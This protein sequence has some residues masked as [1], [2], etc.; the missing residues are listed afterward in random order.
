MR[1]LFFPLICL[2]LSA[3]ALV[4][5]QEQSR[6]VSGQV[7]A[8]DIQSPIADCHVSLYAESKRIAICTT[9]DQGNFSTRRILLDAEKRYTLKITHVNYREESVTLQNEK[10]V[11]VF[12]TPRQQKLDEVVVY[13]SFRNTNKGN[14]YLYTPSEAA[15]S[16]SIVGEPDVVRHIAAMPGVSQGME[17]TLGLYVRGSNN[18]N[19]QILLDGMPVQGSS[20][21]GMFSAF[22]PDMIHETVF[23]MGGTSA[24]SGNYTS[25]LIEIVPKKQYGTPFR[26]KVTLSPYLAGGYLSVPLLKDRISL[27]VG[28][29]LSYLPYIMDYIVNIEQDEDEREDMNGQLM[30]MTA[31][32]DWRLNERNILSA[33]FYTTHDFF[34]YRTGDDQNRL[35]WNSTAFNLHWGSQLAPNMKLDVLAYYTSSYARQEQKTYASYASDQVQSL[36]RLGTEQTEWSGKATWMHQLSD[37]LSYTAGVQVQ[38]L[39]YVP[40]SEKI[41]HQVERTNGQQEEQNGTLSSL[42]GEVNYMQ[43]GRW[44]GK[45]G[46]RLGHWNANGYRT[47]NA[48]FHALIDI[49]L[50]QG[51]GI[52]LTC[53]RMVQYFH[54][55]EGL[56]I[57]WSHSVVTASDRQFREETTHQGY[58]GWFWKHES[59]LKARITAGLFYRRM[60]N[61]LSYINSVNLFGFGDATWRDEVDQG[62]GKAYGLELSATLQGKKFGTTL[63]YTLSR[64]TRRFPFINKGHEFPFKFD[65]RHNL[66]WQGKYHLRSLY[67]KGRKKEHYINATL[68]YSS[69]SRATL[70]VSY[71]EGITPPYWDQRDP[72]WNFPIEVDDNAYGR[73]EMSAVNGFKLKDYF[74]IDAS[75][76]FHCQRSRWS[77]ELTVSVFNLLNWK[78]PYLY[79]HSD[80]GWRQLSIMPV[81]PNIRWAIEF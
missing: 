72:G 44:N 11:R 10:S 17:G 79:Y 49:F 58:A 28:G 30:D 47:W 71:Y 42:F 6:S 15:S 66:N 55:L 67:K 19:N 57:G 33:L 4:H 78:N 12:L 45:V 50:P 31:A 56:P 80:E 63:S 29:R 35:N 24:A 74:R 69:G 65:R 46:F 26:G 32:L 23:S 16:I 39:S 81:M 54:V 18:G 38:A 75:Y 22:Q 73:Q 70:P 13:S 68:T 61:L 2:C 52:E 53:D 48:D 8:A 9:D 76:T 40:L 64:T 21:I 77:H 1:L 37:D 14:S 3:S 25:S 43:T 5:G 59:A 20:H 7:L 51:H 34:D 27:Q 62:K 36:L 41:L 60:N